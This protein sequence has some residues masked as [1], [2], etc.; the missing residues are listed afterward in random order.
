MQSC[1]NYGLWLTLYFRIL[2]SLA[3]SPP[4]TAR[5]PLLTS[6]SNLLTRA[7]Y[8]QVTKKKYH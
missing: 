3:H 5:S 8:E 1:M 6:M 2:T 4:H 7:C